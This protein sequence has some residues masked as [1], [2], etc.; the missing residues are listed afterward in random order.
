MVRDIHSGG[1]PQGK[2]LSFLKYVTSSCY[3]LKAEGPSLKSVLV[4][5]RSRKQV[6][7]YSPELELTPRDLCLVSHVH[8]I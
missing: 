4:V 8:T 1:L 7:G 6:E 5:L 3:N 2:L